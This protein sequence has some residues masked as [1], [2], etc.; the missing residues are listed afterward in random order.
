MKR[1]VVYQSATGFTEKYATWI[2]EKLSCEAK[3]L[4]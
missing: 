4:R 3:E 2:A 1:L